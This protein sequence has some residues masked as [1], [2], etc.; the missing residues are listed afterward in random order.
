M[1]IRFF[2][3]AITC[4]A[5]QVLTA[6]SPYDPY[7]CLHEKAEEMKAD[8]VAF[9]TERVGFTTNEAAL[10]WIQY[11]EFEN[12]MKKLKAIERATKQSLTKNSDEKDYAKV[13]KVMSDIEKKRFEL[14]TRYFEKYKKILSSE[15]LFLYY[16]AEKEYRRFLL[17]KI[18]QKGTGK[19][20]PTEC[21]KNK[22]SR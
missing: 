9:V 4:I 11:N 2:T 7:G 14:K 6:Q 10:F 5:V 16:Q 17:D 22:N 19:G 1:K 8:K 18:A 3:L 13:L 15:K 21:M 20:L 12:E